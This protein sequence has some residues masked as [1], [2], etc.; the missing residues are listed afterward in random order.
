MITNSAIHSGSFTFSREPG[1]GRERVK[2][3]VKGCET[4]GSESE[5][6]LQHSYHI[7]KLRQSDGT[8]HKKK[9]KS[10]IASVKINR[11]TP[12]ERSTVVSIPLCLIMFCTETSIVRMKRAAPISR[13]YAQAYHQLLSHLKIRR[14]RSWVSGQDT[15]ADISDSD[16]MD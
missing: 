3:F 11:V 1:S 5:R 6:L 16:M 7:L 12:S 4:P 13:L 14:S 9:K 8:V 15:H 10:L 2:V